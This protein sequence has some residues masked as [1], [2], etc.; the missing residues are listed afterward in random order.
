MK[1]R[2]YLVYDERAMYDVDEATVLVAS[3]D[4]LAEAINDA[5]DFAPCVIYS[6]TETGEKHKGGPVIGDERF[7][8]YVEAKQ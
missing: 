4:S 6:Y 1:K 5:Q 7:E 8:M 2:I 3:G